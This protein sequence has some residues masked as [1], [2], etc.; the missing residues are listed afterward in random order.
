MFRISKRKILMDIGSPLQNLRW[1]HLPR[2]GTIWLMRDLTG[3][4]FVT[5]LLRPRPA[6]G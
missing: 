4:S 6:E 5:E 3:R 2:I 1:R